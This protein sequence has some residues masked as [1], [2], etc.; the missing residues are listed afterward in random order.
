VEH[1]TAGP[2]A[3]SVVI[4]CRDRPQLLEQALA[5]VVG[6]LRPEDELVVVDSASRD[7][8]VQRVAAAAGA[9]V[10]VCDEPG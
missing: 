1:G 6:A 8:A 5:A 2:P 7:P 10:L 3:L 4:C 9:T